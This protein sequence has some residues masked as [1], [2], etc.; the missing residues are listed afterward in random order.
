VNPSGQPAAFNAGR[1][2]AALESRLHPDEPQAGKVAIGYVAV[3]RRQTLRIERAQVSQHTPKAGPVTGRADHHVRSQPAAVGEEHVGAVES[4]HRRYYRDAPVFQ[5]S[6]KP[7]VKRRGDAVL[8]KPGR[9]AVRMP[10]QAQVSQIPESESFS[11]REKH[12]NDPDRQE[13]H[14]ARQTL[15]R[16]AEEARRNDCGSVAD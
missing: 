12:I 5:R 2:E 16:N 3:D 9:G 4:A 8:R 6:N 14:D 11:E 10:W 1:V 13:T 7:V 15:H